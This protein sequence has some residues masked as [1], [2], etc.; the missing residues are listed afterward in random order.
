MALF[1]IADLHFAF[2]VDKPMDIFGENWKNHSEKIIA[3]WKKYITEEDTVLLPGDL[4]WGMRIDEAAADLD[5]IYSLPGEKFC[6][7][8]T[9]ITGGNPPQN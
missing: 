8:A 9:M 5:V 2:S 6:L 3:S 1:A 4:S 7:A